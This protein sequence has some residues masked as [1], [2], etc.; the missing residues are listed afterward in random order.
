[1]RTCTYVIE[2]SVYQQ[3]RGVKI[4][5]LGIALKGCSYCILAARPVGYPTLGWL[6]RR[7][8]SY[9]SMIG[10]VGYLTRGLTHPGTAVTRQRLETAMHEAN[11][12]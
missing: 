2:L 5:T 4:P 3:Q 7:A 9:A 6:T 11:P 8:I 12:F 1:M 10:Q